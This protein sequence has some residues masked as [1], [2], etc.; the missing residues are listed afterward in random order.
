MQNY[1]LTVNTVDECGIR[2]AHHVIADELGPFCKLDNFAIIS[3]VQND[4]PDWIA[5]TVCSVWVIL[6][7]SVAWGNVDLRLLEFAGNL[8]VLRGM[9]HM[10]ALNGIVGHKASPVTFPSTVSH[11]VALCITDCSHGR[12]SP[13]AEVIERVDPGG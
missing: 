6:A 10:G 5:F 9:D 7:P 4:S 13:E 3:L 8:D 12:R 2:T 11:T 1:G